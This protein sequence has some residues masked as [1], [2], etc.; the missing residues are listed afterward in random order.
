MYKFSAVPRS[1]NVR[2]T[3]PKM[4]SPALIIDT[5][6]HLSNVADSLNNDAAAIK[7]NAFSVVIS[8][9]DIIRLPDIPSN[10]IQSS[11]KK[12]LDVQVHK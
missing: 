12:Y 10:E 8:A 9:S 2:Y 6:M 3:V 7:G 5:F 4:T 1:P 11:C